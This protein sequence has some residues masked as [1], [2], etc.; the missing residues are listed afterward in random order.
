MLSELAFERHD[1]AE[2]EMMV[3]R[4]SEVERYTLTAEDLF[5]RAVA[6]LHCGLCR[7]SGLESPDR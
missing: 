3:Q 7:A 2:V 6:A 5:R 1:W 4:L